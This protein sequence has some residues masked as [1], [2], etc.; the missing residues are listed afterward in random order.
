MSYSIRIFLLI[1]QNVNVDFFRFSVYIKCVDRYSFHITIRVS[2]QN[3]LKINRFF[4]A[5]CVPAD[6]S[7]ANLLGSKAPLRMAPL[8]QLFN[9]TLDRWS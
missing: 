8:V 1:L 3:T 9:I 6:Q 2:S 7:T 4:S 5:L